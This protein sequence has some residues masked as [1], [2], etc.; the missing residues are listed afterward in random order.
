MQLFLQLDSKLHQ[1]QLP[2]FSEVIYNI[3]PL[4]FLKAISCFGNIAQDVTLLL[5]CPL[6]E[7][8]IKLST[9]IQ[10]QHVVTE[11]PLCARPCEWTLCCSRQGPGYATLQFSG[12]PHLLHN[13]VPLLPA[14]VIAV[15]LSRPL[16]HPS[17]STH[18][19]RTPLLLFLA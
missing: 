11:Y 7:D 17:V 19:Y 13:P 4:L 14:A 12:R 16:F 5:E 9:I 15:L 1:C 10:V 3:Q 2:S 6:L 18:R 8:M